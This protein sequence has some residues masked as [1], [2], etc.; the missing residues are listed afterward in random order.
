[1][2][3]ASITMEAADTSETLVND[4]TTWDNNPEVS[5]FLNHCSPT[6][7]STN[8]PTTKVTN[9]PTYL[10]TYLLNCLLAKQID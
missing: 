2:L 6:N 10:P 3:A 7:Q 1:V 4:Q 9:Q 5:R 8:K